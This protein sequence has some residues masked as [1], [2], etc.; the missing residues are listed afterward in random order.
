MKDP[1]K[2]LIQTI[3]VAILFLVVYTGTMLYT[4]KKHYDDLIMADCQNKT[5]VVRGMAEGYGQTWDDIGSGFF[6]EINAHNRLMS[7]RLASRIADGEYSGA[8]F[9]TDRM[10]VRIH[11]GEINLPP[12][13][14]ELFPELSSD[15]ITE[16]YVQ[17]RVYLN[18]G[19]EVFLTSCRIL[20][21]WYYVSW[22]PIETYDEYVTSHLSREGLLEALEYDDDSE[23]FMVASSGADPSTS[24][25][26]PGTIIHKTKGLSRYRSLEDL[27]ITRE[28]LD[29]ENFE[30]QTDNGKRYICSSVEM[31]NAG[32]TIVLC[33]SVEKE[34]AAFLG[35]VISQVL[36]AAIMLAGLVTWCFSVQWLVRKEKLT[37][38]QKQNYTPKAV[39]K[40]TVRLT[41]M[42][43]LVVILFAF[44]TVMVPYMYKENR[45]GTNVLKLFDTQV[46]DEIRNVLD[47]Q[48]QEAQSF[49]RLGETVSEMLTEN[50]AL[51]TKEKLSEISEAI[52]AE[53][54]ILF[55]ENAQEAACSRDYTGFSLPA[56]KS[57]PF[58]D[59][60]KLLKGV[61]LIVHGPETDMITGETRPFVGIR[62]RVPGQTDVF[63]ALLIAI[64]NS[65]PAII[66]ESDAALQLAKQQV[67]QRMQIGNRLIME[68]D[69]K[70]HEIRTCS[71]EE[72]VG[73][74][75]E[76]L[77]MNPK[78]L[79][80]RHM[81]FFFIDDDWYFGISKAS[82]D[83]LSYYLTD[84]SRMSKAGL[85]FAI[86]SGGLFLLGYIIT[87]RFA[88]RDYTEE[89]YERY[90]AQ[91]LEASDGYLKKIADR[92]PSMNSF[93]VTWKNM[94]PEIKTK[95]V[96]QTLTGILL[97]VM[98]LFAFTNSPLSAHSAL[99]FVI[100]GNWTKG[101]NLF[102]IVAVI[103]TLCIE[104]LGYLA[105]KLIFTM[106]YTLTDREGETV[107]RLFRSFIN[108][109]MFIGAVCVS[110]SFLGV[111]TATLLASIGLLSL[112][113]SLG[114]KDIV[115]DILAGLSIVF[116][117]T[118]RV[119]DVVKIG[120]YKGKVL[121][122]GIRS[123]KVL[124][125]NHSIKSV[126]NHEIGSVINFSKRNGRC[127]VKL[128]L[129]ISASITEISKLF[130]EE[131]PLVTKINPYITSGPK[132]EGITEFEGDMM[133]LCVS[134]EG[135]EEYLKSIKRDMNLVLQSM[136]EREL[137][138]LPDSNI[139]INLEGV[140][141]KS[142][143]DS[144]YP[145]M[146]E[147]ILDEG[148]I[149]Q[150]KEEGL[151]AIEHKDRKRRR[152]G[153]IRGT[154]IDGFDEET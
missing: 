70:S 129:P 67:Y 138:H 73:S 133:I 22:T 132:F 154:K 76:S 126:S 149:E 109:A 11:N 136:A 53:Y 87:A 105:V 79:K 50:P 122:I 75:A 120:D 85:L 115:A 27:G 88:M 63:G 51:I 46:E 55:D 151:S 80:E 59:F 84:S 66:E 139:T 16:E 146:P 12:E 153:V 60:R 106:L 26:E 29:E 128:K 56:D 147:T 102:A 71:N 5:E 15:M 95:T 99:S 65:D 37:E 107:L 121:E 62:Y 78:D 17:K 64:P 90:A 134:A 148:T 48:K 4:E 114:A 42:S 21:D 77:G 94:T 6:E 72:Y 43:T 1:V 61:K 13:A 34:K 10:V 45:I 127:E 33:N 32:F 58:Y 123:T 111:D 52:G 110:L 19:K 143:D 96:L 14:E 41:V 152:R 35:D 49:S 20:G 92:S 18:S 44:M 38:K 24:N 112:A 125:G 135:P 74:N 89:S 9:G 28:N 117:K 113:I 31:E 30:F 82:G 130:E 119:G 8:R 57:D 23:I 150:I 3:I 81:G 7:I 98:A 142:P 104:Y 68:I 140:T 40:R 145:D 103:V 86:L 100:R 141:A 83:H 144:T 116:E 54:L 101:I 25:A 118:F 124:D 108:Y 47:V 69:P 93:A 137:L 2:R 91:M 39:K 131:L 97:T 36:F